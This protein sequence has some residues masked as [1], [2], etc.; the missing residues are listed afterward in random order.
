MSIVVYDQFGEEG[1]K[2][3]MGAGPAGAGGP[4]PG[5][6]GGGFPGGTRFL[7]FNIMINC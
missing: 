2:Q 6:A 1:L 5:G 3:G 7:W 4:F